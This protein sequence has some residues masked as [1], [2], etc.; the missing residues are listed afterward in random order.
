MAEKFSSENHAIDALVSSPATR[1]IETAK[2]FASAL[3]IEESSI[4]LKKNIYDASIS[5][6]LEVIN[7]LPESLKSVMLFGHNPGFSQ[8]AYYLTGQPIEMPTCSIV[9]IEIAQEKWQ[10]IVADSGH[11]IHFDYPKKYL[12]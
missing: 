11:L 3:K 1:A 4:F 9:H 2:Y 8:L 12:S 7:A 5:D 10:H 6:L